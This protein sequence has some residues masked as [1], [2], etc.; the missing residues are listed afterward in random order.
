MVASTVRSGANVLPQE[1]RGVR[2]CVRVRR[3]RCLTALAAAQSG[4][5]WLVSYTA[6]LNPGFMRARRDV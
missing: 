1:I 5:F 2:S 4:C 6:S 3:W